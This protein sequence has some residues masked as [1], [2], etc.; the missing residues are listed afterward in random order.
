MKRTVL[1][2]GKST[3]IAVEPQFWQAIHRICLL[4]GWSLVAFVR[5]AKDNETLGDSKDLSNRVR[6]QVLNWYNM[7]LNRYMG[8]A[9]E[10][11]II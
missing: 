6:V 9:K 8:H 2:D 3:S 5:L 7:Q 10:K 11:P 1:I 4:E